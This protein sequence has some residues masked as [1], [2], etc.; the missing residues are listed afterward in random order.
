ME[1]PPATG[2]TDT[3][4][5]EKQDAVIIV[6]LYYLNFEAQE[7]AAPVLVVLVLL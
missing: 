4:T 5:S 6:R 1:A 2:L 3:Y 7:T